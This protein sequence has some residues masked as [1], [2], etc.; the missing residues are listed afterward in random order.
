MNVCP[1]NTLLALMAKDGSA[2]APSYRTRQSES[3]HVDNYNF[4]TS[5]TKKATATN[6]VYKQ[7]LLFV[8]PLLTTPLGA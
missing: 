6:T 3:F 1:P 2:I 4:K 7:W 8:S 5:L